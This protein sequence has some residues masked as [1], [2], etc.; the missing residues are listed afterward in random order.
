MI[1]AED[2]LN[3]FIEGSKMFNEMRTSYKQAEKGA[4]ILGHVAK[5]KEDRSRIHLGVER[6][7]YGFGRR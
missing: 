2:M 3:C 6:R 7:F 1:S 5:S 4:E